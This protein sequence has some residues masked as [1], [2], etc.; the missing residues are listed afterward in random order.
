MLHIASHTLNPILQ[1]E[2]QRTS[3]NALAFDSFQASPLTHAY[4][5]TNRHPY[6]I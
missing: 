2:E 1:V 4:S 3:P 5:D 6:M